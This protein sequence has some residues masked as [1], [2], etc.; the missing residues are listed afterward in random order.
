MTLQFPE[1]WRGVTSVLTHDWLTGMRGGERCLEILCQGFPQAP[2]YTLVH[3]PDRVSDT[4]NRHD[5]ITTPLQAPG[6]RRFFR[7]ALPLFPAFIERLQ[8]PQADVLISTSHC[9]AKGINPA[10][11]TRHVCYCFTPMRYGLFYNEYFGKNPLKEVVVRPWLAALRRWDVRA[12]DRVDRFVAISEH[13]RRRIQY[14]YQREADLVYPPVDTD[15][16]TPGP[17]C[18]ED[19]D[20]IVSALV[21]YKRIQLAVEAYNRMG[22]PLRI[23]GTGSDYQKLRR[24]AGPTIAFTGWQTDTQ[25]LEHYRGCRFFIFPGEED[26]GIAP[27]EAQA[28][29]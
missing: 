12:S 1:S 24:L 25:I 15:H 6:I 19:Y 2:I 13:V 28:C 17:S 10:E 9:V 16:Y 3:E 21:P 11:G 22:L 7:A 23:V 8:P 20:L 26:F 29:G 27:V 4:I 14:L 18:S 5:I